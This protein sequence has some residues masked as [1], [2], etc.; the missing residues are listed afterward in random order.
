MV[1]I[2]FDFAENI[3]QENTHVPF[4]VLMIEVEFAQKPQ[5]LAVNWIFQTINF[6]NRNFEFLVSINLI[7]RGMEQ[8]AFFRVSFELFGD[9][10]KSEAELT[11]VKAVSIMIIN[12][13]RGVIPGL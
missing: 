10:E 1:L 11:N 3:K 5:I 8:R 4:Q 2:I 12:G 6:E 13:V 7:S 9:V